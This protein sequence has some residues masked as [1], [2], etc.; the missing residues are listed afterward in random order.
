MYEEP[1][2][3]DKLVTTNAY[4]NLIWREMLI[5]LLPSF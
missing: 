4:K 5:K 1:W 2:D 3:I